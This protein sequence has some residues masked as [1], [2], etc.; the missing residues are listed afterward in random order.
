MTLPTSVSIN[1]FPG[2]PFFDSF[3]EHLLKSPMYQVLCWAT[4]G[5]QV[6]HV[7]SLPMRTFGVEGGTDMGA[8][9]LLRLGTQE[10]MMPE[11]LV[12]VGQTD[13]QQTIQT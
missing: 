10:G 11:A 13:K 2:N 9:P 7:R 8:R 6:S 3:N 1:S 5:T 12:L 4:L